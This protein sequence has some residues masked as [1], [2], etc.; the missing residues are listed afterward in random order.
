MTASAQEHS[1]QAFSQ[2]SVNYVYSSVLALSK[3]RRFLRNNP[4][5]LSADAHY[6][7]SYRH[8]TPVTD[9]L[10]VQ[11]EKR[12]SFESLLLFRALAELELERD[13]QFSDPSWLKHLLLS[14]AKG[15]LG[16][17]ED[18]L[19]E[20]SEKFECIVEFLSTGTLSSSGNGE[21]P[22]CVSR[23]RSRSKRRNNNAPTDSS[24]PR[25]CFNFLVRVENINLRLKLS[26]PANGPTMGSAFPFL[27]LQGQHLKVLLEADDQG[28]GWGALPAVCL[29]LSLQDA[30]VFQ[31]LSQKPCTTSS[32][33][34]LVTVA[35]RHGSPSASPSPTATRHPFIPLFPPDQPQQQFS[36]HPLFFFSIQFDPS[37]VLENSFPPLLTMTGKSDALDV[38]VTPSCG[39]ML[40]AANIFSSS[41]F[42]K[43]REAVPLPADTGAGSAFDLKATLDQA[44]Q[45]LGLLLSVENMNVC[46]DFTF[47]PLH[48]IVASS[49]QPTE[50]P[51]TTHTCAQESESG[52]IDTHKL[53]FNSGHVCLTVGEKERKGGASLEMFDFRI[54]GTHAL[55]LM[56]TCSGNNNGECTC[57]Q[58]LSQPQMDDVILL[59]PLDTHASAQLRE[60]IMEEGEED[61]DEC[62]R[63]GAVRQVVRTP[64]ASLSLLLTGVSFTLSQHKVEQ[65]CVILHSILS[66]CTC[67]PFSVRS[68][69]S[70]AECDSGFSMSDEKDSASDDDAAFEDVLDIFE[71]SETGFSDDDDFYSLDSGSEAESEGKCENVCNLSRVEDD[72]VSSLRLLQATRDN[73][74]R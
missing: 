18:K 1:T 56:C 44:S 26:A 20:K 10:M 64:T 13:R 69:D 38:F 55:V 2:H 22:R 61:D 23:E 15:L 19:E 46:A 53:I 33:P 45:T 52:I 40:H 74:M 6:D 57:W 58:S 51:S 24:F 35:C 67:Q 16:G 27:S 11:L 7:L 36:S 29:E 50:P 28:Q 32:P 54:T 17:G 68:R 31:K 4:G 70:L 62:S 49:S 5:T 30:A 25:L 21:Q 37:S 59:L 8:F 60:K 12:L 43:Q 63:E 71:A 66:S 65:I 48:V 42:S 72:D 34:P 73:I 9:A 3:R 39:E 47:S 14:T 41:L